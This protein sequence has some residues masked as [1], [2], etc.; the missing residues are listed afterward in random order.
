MMVRDHFVQCRA[1]PSDVKMQYLSL[2]SNTSPGA[3]D[4]KRY[5]VESAQNLGMHDSST[6]IFLVE[7]P[8]LTSVISKFNANGESLNIT[9]TKTLRKSIDYEGGPNIAS[10][11]DTVGISEEKESPCVQENNKAPQ[12]VFPEDSTLLSSPYLYTLMSN[13][14]RIYLK[15]S[16]RVSVR[17]KLEIGFPGIGCKYC[18]SASRGGLGRIFPLKRK[19]LNDKMGVLHN[20]LIRCRLCPNEMKTLLIEQHMQFVET[21]QN[22][23]SS[24]FFS[25]KSLE[26]NVALDA[27]K[28]FFDRI[29]VR[30]HKD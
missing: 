9:V 5:W 28:L 15:E 2:K 26:T 13:T 20:H 4:S 25:K 12:I 19:N 22:D 24:K 17:K 6:G 1:M 3:A 7:T 18:N 29:W 11:Q 23:K 8:H 16:E 30:L 21:Q 14:K 10:N 27:Q